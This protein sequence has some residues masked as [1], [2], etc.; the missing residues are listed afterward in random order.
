M[1]HYPYDFKQNQKVQS[2][3]PSE[4]PKRG[5]IARL[6]FA[7]PSAA[8]VADIHAAAASS[9]AAVAS[10]A[11]VEAASAPTD[12]LTVAAPTALG[13]APNVLDLLLLTAADDTL[14]VSKDD[15]TGVITIELADTTAA[16]NTAANCQ[17]AI[18]ALST[19][20]G[21]DV[22]AFTATA[23][24]NWDTAA[25]ATGETGAVDFAGG[26][27]DTITTSITNPDFPRAVTATSGG[28][29]GDIGAL[30]VTVV[31]T[32]INDEVITEIL[33]TFTA[34]SATTVTG[35]KAFKTITSY[36]VPAHDGIGAT[37]SI[38]TSGKLGI[39]YKLDHNTVMNAFLDNALE[40]TAPTV[41]TSA[42]AVE[43]NTVD[44]NSALDG[45]KVDV[46]LVATSID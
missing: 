25:I 20:A 44:L 4:T 43:S 37:T 14:A 46:Y 29:A 11:A 33:P 9:G 17:T 26:I 36:E 23:G 27:T 34:N 24:G 10:S 18:R 3:V 35:S 8:A 22:S 1:Q 16:N 32:N 31:G 40:G 42:T 5:F 19:V 28:T 15:D 12:T 38:G 41:A 6:E 2:D 13:A 7:D 30:Q 21:V 39:P 45:S